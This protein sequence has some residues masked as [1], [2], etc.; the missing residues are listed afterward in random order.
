M[1]DSVKVKKPY[2]CL[3]CLHAGQTCHQYKME[4]L[5][6]V[7][8]NVMKVQVILYLL[9]LLGRKLR[10][11]WKKPKEE[12]P[13]VLRGYFWAC[14]WMTMGTWAAIVQLCQIHRYIGTFYHHWLMP[15]LSLCLGM[16]WVSIDYI[17]R[18]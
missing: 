13:K 7:G 4:K 9:P 8:F 2:N 18:I 11:I 16:C 10:E 14:A 3:E 5:R 6:L 12:I 1:D 15:I 17:S